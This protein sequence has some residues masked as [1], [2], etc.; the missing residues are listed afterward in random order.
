MKHLLAILLVTGVLGSGAVAH[1]NQ[2]PGICTMEYAPVCAAKQVYCIRAPCYPVY[3]TYG[4]LCQMSGDNAV[5]IHQGECTSS[6]TGPV[7]PVP[8]NTP[9]SAPPGSVGQPGKPIPPVS[10]IAT[11]TGSTTMTATTSA[12]TT[13]IQKLGFLHSLW[14][15][16]IYWLTHI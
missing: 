1:A 3:Q 10:H 4:N 15:H 2:S 7:K 16:I 13:T 8:T 12:T 11:S 5:L 14:A 9:P 6:E